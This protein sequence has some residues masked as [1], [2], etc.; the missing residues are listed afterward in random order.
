MNQKGT[1]A[2]V[3]TGGAR[4]QCPF[5]LNVNAAEHSEIRIVVKRSAN[6]R[7]WQASLNGQPLCKSA[8]PL[9]KAARRLIEMGAD[10]RRTIELWHLGASSW[11][12]RGVLGAVAST[13]IDGERKAT[14]F[15]TKQV[16]ARSAAGTATRA[17]RAAP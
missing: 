16:T 8:A 1:S 13:T 17:W 5:G 15:A 6:G 9:I 10:P 7:K 12:M 2:P 11:A 14:H 4:Q 3:G